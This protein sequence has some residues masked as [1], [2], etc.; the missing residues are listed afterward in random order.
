MCFALSAS[1][2]RELNFKIT[3]DGLGR[4]TGIGCYTSIA[5]RVQW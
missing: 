4:V 2:E 5:C 1:S 3:V